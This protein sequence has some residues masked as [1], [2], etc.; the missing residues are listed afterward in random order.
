MKHVFTIY[1]M[2]SVLLLFTVSCKKKEKEKTRE[3]LRV[4]TAVASKS[5]VIPDDLILA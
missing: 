3:E 2:C 4:E 1:F 5:A